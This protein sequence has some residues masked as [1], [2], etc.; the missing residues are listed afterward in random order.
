MQPQRQFLNPVKNLFWP[1]LHCKQCQTDCRHGDFRGGVI[2]GI[3]ITQVSRERERLN[4]KIELNILI[5][6][7][8]FFDTAFLALY[9]HVSAV[10]VHPMALGLGSLLVQFKHFLYLKAFK[11]LKTK[12][13]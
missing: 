4:K 5:S 1:Q 6:T 8:L 13:N 12:E 2:F 3:N 11:M 7:I 10:V 9:E